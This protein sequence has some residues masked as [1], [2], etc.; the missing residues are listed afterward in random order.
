MTASSSGSLLRRFRRGAQ[1]VEF[2]LVFPVLFTITG[3]VIDYAWFFTNELSIQQALR[4]ASRYGA[5]SVSPCGNARTQAVTNLT[6]LGFTTTT[7]SYSA[8]VAA[9]ANGVKLL[10]L[11]LHTDSSGV[12]YG[13]L[14]LPSLMMPA[15]YTGVA[16]YRVED[17]TLG[18]C[19]LTN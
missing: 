13:R 14:L 12:P 9:D 8:I 6:A 15:N 19:S 11:T 4:D 16:T 5:A 17:Q 3:V 2:A 10:T 7:A 1:A 18:T